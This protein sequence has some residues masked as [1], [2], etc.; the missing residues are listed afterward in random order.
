MPQCPLHRLPSAPCPL[1]P[2][3][4]CLH[5]WSHRAGMAECRE[6]SRAEAEALATRWL[7]EAVAAAENKGEQMEMV[8]R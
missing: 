2:C 1:R 8:K 6:V 4:E 5:D 7:R 3:D